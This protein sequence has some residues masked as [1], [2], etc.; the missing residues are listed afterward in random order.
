MAKALGG[1]G[2]FVGLGEGDGAGAHDK[3]TTS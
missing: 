1:F 3:V 2:G